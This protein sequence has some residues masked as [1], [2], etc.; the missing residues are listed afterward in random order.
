[1]R[2]DRSCFAAV[3]LTG[4]LLAG[5]A[6]AQ[7]STVLTRE[8]LGLDAKYDATVITVDIPA[9]P[10]QPATTVGV[11]GHRHPGSTYA[12]VTKGEVVSRLGDGAERRYKAGDAWSE[13]PG[14]PHYIVNASAT[15]PAQLVVVMVLPKLAAALSEPLS[16]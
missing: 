11:A 12:Y 16:K 1:M 2:I 6:A 14:Q 4:L 7:V 10:K 5:S 8:P 3:G 9:N 15:Q 13:T